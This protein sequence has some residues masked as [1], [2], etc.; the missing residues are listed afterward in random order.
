MGDD[1]I[2]DL[3]IDGERECKSTIVP[4]LSIYHD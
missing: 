4:L 2:D 1:F 3:V